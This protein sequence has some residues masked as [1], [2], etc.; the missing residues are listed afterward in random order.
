LSVFRGFFSRK[1]KEGSSDDEQMGWKLFGKV[2]PK[3]VNSKDPNQIQADYKV[4]QQQS[5]YR[6]QKFHSSYHPD[7]WF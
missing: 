5:E 2:P 6:A 1:S 3:P 7:K 4:T